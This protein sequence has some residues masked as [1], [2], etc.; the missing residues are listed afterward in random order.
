MT[1]DDLRRIAAQHGL[2]RLGDKHLEQL[3]QSVAANE[4]LTRRLPKDLHWGEESALV[5]RLPVPREAR[6]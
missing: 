5:F 6:R 4:A 1:K 3:A 2:T